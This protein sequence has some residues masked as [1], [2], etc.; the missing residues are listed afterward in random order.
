MQA[1]LMR[2]TEANT[3]ELRA[4]VRDQNQKSAED[5]E[6][7]RA[8]FRNDCLETQVQEQSNLIGKVRSEVTEQ[9]L[10][11]VWQRINEFVRRS[12]ATVVHSPLVLSREARAEN[13][14]AR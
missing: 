12:H 4:T 2:Q 10:D 1:D 6:T 5:L 8:Q 11:C 7:L 13:R 14:R 9:V 3:S